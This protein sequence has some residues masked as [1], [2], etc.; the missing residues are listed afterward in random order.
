MFFEESHSFSSYRS[1][2]EHADCD[3]YRDRDVAPTMVSDEN[4][5]K[6]NDLTTDG[7]NL[8][9]ATGHMSFVEAL[10]EDSEFIAVDKAYSAYFWYGIAGVIE[11]VT[12]FNFSSNLTLRAR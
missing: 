7:Y 1:N 12:L 8:S 2:H 6:S 5:R 9:D 11:I 3:C 4:V 10:L